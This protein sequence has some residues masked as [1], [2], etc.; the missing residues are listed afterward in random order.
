MEKIP[1]KGKKFN[2][3]FTSMKT[4]AGRYGGLFPAELGGTLFPVWKRP[5]TA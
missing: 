5:L 3:L 2:S 1:I 4:P